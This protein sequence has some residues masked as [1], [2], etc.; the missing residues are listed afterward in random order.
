MD[1]PV[2]MCTL[3]PRL[4]GGALTLPRLPPPRLTEPPGEPPPLLTLPLLPLPPEKPLPLPPEKPLLPPP[5]LL[6]PP[7][8][9]PPPRPIY[10]TLLNLFVISRTMAF[11]FSQDAS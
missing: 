6:L 10:I 5:P 1:G 4:L 8:P 3:G 11:A 9:P 2:C 7:P